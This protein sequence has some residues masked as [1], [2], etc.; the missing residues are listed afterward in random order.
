MFVPVL[1]IIMSSQCL[2]TLPEPE[3]LSDADFGYSQVVVKHYHGG[4][5]GVCHFQRIAEDGHVKAV[6]DTITIGR[7][8]EALRQNKEWPAPTPYMLARL[9]SADEIII[10]HSGGRKIAF[11]MKHKKE[12]VMDMNDNLIQARERLYPG[13][14]EAIPI[15]RGHTQPLVGKAD[16]LQRMSVI[17]SPSRLNSFLK[18]SE[19]VVE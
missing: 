15:V 6:A 3:P 9:S 13:H 10:S 14:S 11:Q 19:D 7:L 8:F 12:V 17:R 5:T 2:A 16:A 4:M 1:L 18:E